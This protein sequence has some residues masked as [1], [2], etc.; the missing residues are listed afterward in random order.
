[1]ALLGHLYCL[2]VGRATS[3]QLVGFSLSFG[4]DEDTCTR[5]QNLK[6]SQLLCTVLA[7]SGDSIVFLPEQV[8]QDE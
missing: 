8:L 6:P 4:I 5:T 7:I 2:E 1:M 3:G